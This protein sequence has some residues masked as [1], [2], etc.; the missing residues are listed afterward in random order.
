[1]SPVVRLDDASAFVGPSELS[2]AGLSDWCSSVHR[3]A[4]RGT[5]RVCYCKLR[6]HAEI[7]YYM[8]S[9]PDYV[10]K[11]SRVSQNCT[12]FPTLS[13]DMPLSTFVY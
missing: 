10:R 11:S 13:A 6:Q 5:S 2:G 1:M 7:I 8:Y 12:L 4:T 9:I 3:H